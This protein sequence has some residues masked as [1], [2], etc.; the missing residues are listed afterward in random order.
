MGVGTIILLEICAAHESAYGTKR[1]STIAHRCPLLGV[2]RTSTGAN[3]MSAFDPTR[4]LSAQSTIAALTPSD[5]RVT[6]TIVVY[7]GSDT[8]VAKTTISQVVGP[9]G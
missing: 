1:T 9:H 6:R 5:D 8:M 4:I 2:K 3:P 7:N